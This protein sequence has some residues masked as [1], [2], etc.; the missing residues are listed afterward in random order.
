MACLQQMKQHADTIAESESEQEREGQAVA[1]Q[2]I[3]KAPGTSCLHAISTQVIQ[4]GSTAHFDDAP[5]Q[6]SKGQPY[7]R[8]QKRL[9]NMNGQATCLLTLLTQMLGS[10]PICAV[11]MESITKSA[12]G[13]RG[14][15]STD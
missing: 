8:Q 7:A 4:W 3:H 2:W 5:L 12:K 14:H 1:S 9:S 15:S 13:L 11:R 10:R 6:T